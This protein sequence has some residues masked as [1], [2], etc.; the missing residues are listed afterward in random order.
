MANPRGTTSDSPRPYLQGSRIARGQLPPQ[1]GA[2]G[3]AEAAAVR[4]D[5]AW[6]LKVAEVHQERMISMGF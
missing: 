3:A 1:S 4:T 5:L 2:Q 6:M